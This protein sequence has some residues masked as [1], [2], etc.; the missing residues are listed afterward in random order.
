MKWDNSWSLDEHTNFTIIAPYS[1]H[2]YVIRKVHAYQKL[3]KLNGTFRL[4]VY[5]NGTILKKKTKF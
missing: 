2:E 5:A 3:F 4:L 1:L